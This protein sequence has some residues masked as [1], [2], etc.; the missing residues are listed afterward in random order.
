MC[1]CPPSLAWN[2]IR[3]ISIWCSSCFRV[4]QWTPSQL[5]PVSCV[6]ASSLRQNKILHTHLVVTLSQIYV[7]QQDI[8][9]RALAPFYWRRISRNQDADA[10]YTHYHQDGILPRDPPREAWAAACLTA[11]FLPFAQGH[12]QDSSLNQIFSSQCTAFSPLPSAQEA[13]WYG[14]EWCVLSPLS[15]SLGFTSQESQ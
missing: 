12:S 10:K 7:S 4:C 5:T 9:P 6:S 2:S 1:S 8:S 13:D 3:A 14:L 15:L 11:A